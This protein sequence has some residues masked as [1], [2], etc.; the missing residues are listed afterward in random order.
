MPQNFVEF[1]KLPNFL[2]SGTPS[3]NW[4]QAIITLPPTYQQHF[5]TVWHYHVSQVIVGFLLAGAYLYIY[6]MLAILTL[7]HLMQAI[8]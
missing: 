1:L 8:L 7:A 2:I 6:S 4:L 5:T 3:L